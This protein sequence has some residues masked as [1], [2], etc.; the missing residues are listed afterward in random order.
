M[1]IKDTVRVSKSLSW[2]L[3]HGAAKENIELDEEGYANLDCILRK[4]KQKSGER[5]LI[6]SDIE[7][8]VVNCPKQRFKLHSKNNMKLIRANQGHTI[9][10]V[11]NAANK[12]LLA[13]LSVALLHGT[14]R[15]NWEIIKASGLSRMKR[16]HVHMVGADRKNQHRI[17]ADVWIRIDMERALNDGIVFFEAENG[18]ILSPGDSNGIIPGEYLLL[19]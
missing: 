4:L 10:R 2:L 1:T 11:T 19:E 5:G 15:A 12:Q 16:N 14:S 6:A 3:R 18:V 13:P 7:A 9:S 17:R 8:I